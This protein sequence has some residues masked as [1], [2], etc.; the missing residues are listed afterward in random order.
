[1]AG[2]WGGEE[3]LVVAPDTDTDAALQLGERIRQA[4]AAE[5]IA[6]E[7]ADPVAVTVSVGV[8]AGVDDVDAIV[9]AA[10]AALYQAKDRGRNR[11]ELL[12]GDAA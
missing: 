3:F 11:V 2:R 12:D 1:V 4:A 8:A 10:D 9:R 7:G 6:V 5:P